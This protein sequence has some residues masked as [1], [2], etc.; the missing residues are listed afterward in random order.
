MLLFGTG[1]DCTLKDQI[2][3]HPVL[4][5]ALNDPKNGDSAAKHLK[6]QVCLNHTNST[7]NGLFVHLSEANILFF[8]KYSINEILFR[9][10]FMV[11]NL[12]FKQCCP[13]IY[14]KSLARIG[15]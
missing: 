9:L 15:F 4:H 12:H 3:S 2:M 8:S 13:N 6:Q 10:S 1:L 14:G 11:Q 7:K 5:D